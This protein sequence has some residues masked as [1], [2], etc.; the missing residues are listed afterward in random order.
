MRMLRAVLT[1]V[2]RTIRR[3]G[4]LVLLAGAIV[5]V[6]LVRGDEAS[7]L[8]IRTP[9]FELLTS[10]GKS[11]AVEILEGLESYCTV[12]EERLGHTPATRRPIR[13]VLFDREWDLD[14]YKPV[15][16]PEESSQS[17]GENLWQKY[18]RE[19]E[20]MGA[21]QREYGRVMR[22]LPT[23]SG[24]TR[25]HR[26]IVWNP[27]YSGGPGRD[28]DYFTFI[29]EDSATVV[30]SGDRRWERTERLLRWPCARIHLARLRRPLP[31]WYQDGLVALLAQVRVL[32]DEYAFGAWDGSRG[33][34][35]EALDALAP[36]EDFLRRTEED[37][38][39]AVPGVRYAHTAQ[40]W[41]F[42]QYAHYD[43]GRKFGGADAIEA[44]LRSWGRGND[45][46][47]EV[48][49]RETGQSLA[50]ID[51][52]MQR[53]LRRKRSR[54]EFHPLAKR[55]KVEAANMVTVPASELETLFMELRV[56]LTRD[57]EMRDVLKARLADNEQDVAALT[58]LGWQARQD[59]EVQQAAAWWQRAVEAGSTVSAQLRAQPQ[60]VIEEK[61]SSGDFATWTGG[62][63]ARVDRWR[64]QLIKILELDPSDESAVEVLAWVEAF[65]ESPN[66]VN[67]HRIRA[68]L[69]Q[70]AWPDRTQLALAHLRLRADALDA[71][72][73][74][75]VTHLR[76]GRGDYVSGVALAL[77]QLHELL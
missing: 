77:M 68:R 61:W 20:W 47:A 10:A 12:L 31:L 58:L 72:A 25:L 9:H 40:A 60:A 36:W 30:L 4:C 64:A 42:L 45:D 33:D 59:G 49:V 51:D 74:E 71:E 62:E 38:I 28:L 37:E 15:S 14:P 16:E 52:A 18:E 13:I 11:E 65:A 67:L 8:R 7:W 41:L 19:L 21:K 56:R 43:Q 50:G 73:R 66:E 17:T 69:P 1:E 54:E 27:L 29:D 44:I 76:T 24:P 34:F 39:F 57:P 48:F 2:G 32:K 22:A 53:M 63:K 75:T 35:L 5:A 70:L 3:R 46:V 55:G 23:S 26:Q 6:S